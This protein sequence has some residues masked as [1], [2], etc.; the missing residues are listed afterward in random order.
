MDR[1]SLYRNITYIG[2]LFVF[3]GV[4]ID[5]RNEIVDG[6]YDIVYDLAAL[7]VFTFAFMWLKTRILLIGL[8]IYS[9]VW[10]IDILLNNFFLIQDF[11]VSHSSLAKAALLVFVIAYACL[12]LGLWSNFKHRY[13]SK[14]I[15]F[16]LGYIV[17]GILI[18]TALIQVLLRV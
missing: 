14:E 10:N 6:I 16:R 7:A 15:S 11:P 1:D 12:L 4:F 5:P 13:F 17:S 9:L 8:L 18:I 3:I 2:A